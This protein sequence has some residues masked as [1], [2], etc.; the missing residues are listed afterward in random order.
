M[1]KISALSILALLFSGCFIPDGDD[2]PDAGPP[3]PSYTDCDPLNFSVTAT[4]DSAGFWPEGDTYGVNTFYVWEVTASADSPSGYVYKGTTR[5]VETRL[6]T[7]DWPIPTTYWSAIRLAFDGLD[8]HHF[9]AD[10][11]FYLWYLPYVD[12]ASW[13]S[14]TDGYNDGTCPDN[15]YEI[16]GR[17]RCRGQNQL[18]PN[19]PGLVGGRTYLFQMGMLVPL[20]Y[21]GE[22]YVQSCYRTIITD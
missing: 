19:A 5:A 18:D 17:P 10:D 12:G 3:P 7:R 15:D 1:R 14:K 4:L 8:P 21:D 22:K 2:Q 11:P 13:E 16:N 20:G 9:A 6:P